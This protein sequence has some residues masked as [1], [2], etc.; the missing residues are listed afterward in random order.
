MPSQ[1][2]PQP[3]DQSMRL[4]DLHTA[5]LFLV[6]VLRL[7][8]APRPSRCGGGWRDGFVAIGAEA[9][10]A[11]AFDLLYN[12][13]LQEPDGILALQDTALG[14]VEVRLL[15]MTSLLQHRRYGAID[16]CLP[17]WTS[18]AA[19]QVLP[20][21]LVLADALTEAGLWVPLRGCELGRVDLLASQLRPRG[22]LQLVH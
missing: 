3:Y 8:A 10:A 5:E 14:V 7:R 2:K 22:G 13:L 15:R 4:A 18:G 17:G 9:R 16:A 20:P 21:A 1:C 19:D 12:G 11:T 6:T